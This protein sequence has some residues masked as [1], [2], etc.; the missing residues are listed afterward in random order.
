MYCNAFGKQKLFDFRSSLSNAVFDVN[1][2]G[3][4]REG[5]KSNP[6]AYCVFDF[7]DDLIN[8][9]NYIRV[10][11]NDFNYNRIGA[12]SVVKNELTE[13]QKIKLASAKTKKDIDKI[14]DE[15]SNNEIKVTKI[16]KGYPLSE[17]TWNE[18]RANF[19]ALLK[20]DVELE[21]PKNNFGLTKIDS[22][23]FRNYTLIKDGILNVT[24]LPLILTLNTYNKLKKKS[25]LKFIKSEYD[26]S[27]GKGY[28]RAIIDISNL[29]VIN[30]KLTKSVKC[31]EMTDT[32]LNLMEHKFALKYLK[33]LQKNKC[34]FTEKVAKGC[35]YFSDYNTAQWL[36]GLGLTEDGGY[37]PKTETQKSGDYYMALT[38]KSNFNSF[39]S[40][41]K[42]EDVF[43]KISAGKN[44]TPSEN[45]MSNI[46][47]TVD[48]K[49]ADLKL[50]TDEEVAINKLITLISEDKLRVARN[51]AKMKFALIL[52]RK[53]FSDRKGFDDNH[54]EI[55]NSYGDTLTIDYNF[56][57]TKQ[58]L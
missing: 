39:S 4:Y 34:T 5:Y 18:D 57:E 23:I 28:I 22:F 14:V 38:F 13:N 2:R 47:K 27:D 46:I 7:I 11:S 31:E 3:D 29:P 50:S 12:K 53:W 10:A 49:L 43:K 24:Q 42:I 51:L 56:T 16:D 30:K 26:D 15:L 21:L 45:F 44:L 52:S 32:A 19:S 25:S 55:V 35:K 33:Y 58:Y 37:S 6:N 54:A 48:K 8:D 17:F 41:P 1:Q 20:I 36:L 40:I 9:N